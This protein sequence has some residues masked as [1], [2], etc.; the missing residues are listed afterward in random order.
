MPTT[1]QSPSDRTHRCLRCGHVWQ[2]FHA[3]GRPMV[4]S[5]CNSAYWDMPPRSEWPFADAVR[6]CITEAHRIVW[7]Y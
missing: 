1:I 3:T 4:C 2:S 6:S 5:A 7:S